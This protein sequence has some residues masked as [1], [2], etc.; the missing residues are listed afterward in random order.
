MIAP[1]CRF[2]RSLLVVLRRNIHRIKSY[3]HCWPYKVDNHIHLKHYGTESDHEWH[4]AWS[5]NSRRFYCSCRTCSNGELD[6]MQCKLEKM[7]K[8]YVHLWSRS[9]RTRFSI[10]ALIKC[11]NVLDPLVILTKF[12]IRW[13]P[14][15]CRTET[16]DS[17]HILHVV[18][19]SDIW[20]QLLQFRFWTA[21]FTA[22]QKH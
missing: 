7:W 14:S 17:N 8:G 21:P 10:C 5:Q 11:D 2:S 13:R 18:T 1:N 19:T 12:P 16:R 20:F 3:V 9:I 15:Q 22:T 6:S 4:A